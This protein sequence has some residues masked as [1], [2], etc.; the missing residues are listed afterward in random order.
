MN[1]NLSTDD[2]DDDDDVADDGYGDVCANY[3]SEDNNHC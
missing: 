2:D 3:I 1:L